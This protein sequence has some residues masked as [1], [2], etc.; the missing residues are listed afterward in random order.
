MLGSSS[1]TRSGGFAETISLGW[2]QLHRSVLCSE[3][4]FITAFVISAVSIGVVLPFLQSWVLISAWRLFSPGEGPTYEGFF[5]P[6]LVVDP[7]WR[8]GAC[9]QQSKKTSNG[10]LV[11]EGGC[12]FL[13]ELLFSDLRVYSLLFGSKRTCLFLN[14]TSQSTLPRPMLPGHFLMFCGFSPSGSTFFS[15]FS[16]ENV[17]VLSSNLRFVCPPTLSCYCRFFRTKR[18]NFLLIAWIF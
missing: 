3:A 13:P 1:S 8:S 10:I 9:K 17:A 4:T 14:T 7:T 16:E 15:F 6:V 11:K 12:D 18:I 2:E 5:F